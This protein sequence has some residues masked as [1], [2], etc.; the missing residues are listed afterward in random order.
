MKILRIRFRNINS[1]Y[2]EHPAIDFTGS[3]LSTTGLFII[4][5]ATGAGKSTLLDVITLALYN[6]VP[7]FGR[8]ISKTEID[9]QGSVVNLKAADEARSEAYAEVEYEARGKQYR[10]RWS[11]AKNRNG[12]WNNYQMEIAELPS[13]VLL[14]VKKLSD[15]PEVNAQLI[16]LRY[17]QFVKSIILA[18]GSFA[19]FLKAD[20]NARGRLLEDITGTH[21]Y[22]KLGAAAFEKDKEWAEKLRLK[23]AE[24]QGVRLLT[25]E[26]ITSLHQKRQQA[27]AE[28][29]VAETQ[30]QYWDTEKRLLEEEKV[31]SQKLEKLAQAQAALHQQLTAFAPSEEQLRQHES[32]RE[33]ASDLALLKEKNTSRDKLQQQAEVLAKRAQQLA[34]EHTQLLY[35]GGLL[36]GQNDVTSENWL[37]SLDAFEKEILALEGQ[38]KEQRAQASPLMAAI[39]Q[40]VET[41]RVPFLQ[42]LPVKDLEASLA[43]LEQEWAKQQEVLTRFPT[44]FEAESAL[45]KLGLQERSLNELSNYLTQRTFLEAE[46]KSKKTQLE[47]A[48]QVLQQDT[49]RLTQLSVE[50]EKHAGTLTQLREQRDRAYTRQ[51]FEE[52]R[53]QLKEGEEC[54]LCGSLHHPFVHEYLTNFLDLQDAIQ[55]AEAELKVLQKQE[56]TLAAS[57]QAAQKGV[58]TLAP[59]LEK[60]R[61]GFRKLDALVKD[62][63]ASLY[64]DGELD[65][66]QL[67]IRKVAI[68]NQRN[69][70]NAWRIAQQTSEAIQ[71]L[72]GFFGQLQD[73]R[74]QVLWQQST[75]KKRYAGTDIQAD[76]NA[77]RRRWQAWENTTKTTAEATLENQKQQVETDQVL[78]D[79]RRTL[80][81]HLQRMGVPSVEEANARLLPTEEYQRLKHQREALS[82]RHKQLAGEEKAVREDL[83][84]KKAARQVPEVLLDDLLLQT[85]KY[86][87]FRDQ[88]LS[89]AATYTEQL[90][91]NAR[92][93]QRFA[94]LQAE[95]TEL[96]H[97]R[98]KWEL[99]KK[100]IGDATG[101]TFSNFAQSL[102]LSNLIGLANLRLR[103][104]SDRY[105]LDKPRNEADSLFVLDT[106]QGNLPRAVTTLSGGE[107]FTLSL[108]LALAL[109]DLAS[110]NVRIESLFI[111]EGFGTLDPDSLET[112]LDT[113]EKLQS[114]SQKIVG[115][116]SHRH[117]MKDRIPVQ[118]QVEK[119]TDGTSRV[120]MVG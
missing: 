86:R 97:Q 7:R 17:E 10:S 64:P 96:R 38:I 39:Q 48:R 77:L 68:A 36:T 101:N 55:R 14:D 104:L 27:E 67:E 93:Q 11:I 4:S 75:L 83:A 53:K 76:A 80:E 106:Y 62:L 60:L 32:V 109:S 37:A 13:G 24:M 40:E 58:D 52:Q 71:R 102:T 31:L 33:F 56:Q 44:D 88:Y 47:E 72:K 94:H 119:G 19:E 105:M 110:R 79:L 41:S 99:L 34:N 21:L 42:K 91:A 3:P 111:D 82:D 116:I 98:H 73:F 65:K 69:Q 70:V 108:A 95:L 78:T 114:D 35:E 6:E 63:A 5:G 85:E 84:G 23:E 29:Q 26:E 51:S 46:G 25:D 59:E 15:Y 113:L 20:K 57:L 2:G 1:F 87:K 118:I 49:P 16:G 22:R 89:E 18:Q 120:H 66:E 9:K 92:N 43:I 54:P 50:L 100:F 12:N 112:A 117:E 45:E 115:V 30:Y 74:A 90:N 61:E 107:T 103:L 81:D 8:T 28:R